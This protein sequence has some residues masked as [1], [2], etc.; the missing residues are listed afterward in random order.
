MV[1]LLTPD[2]IDRPQGSRG[3]TRSWGLSR[4]ITGPTG[5]W[6][7]LVETL[8]TPD[9]SKSVPAFKSVTDE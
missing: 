5:S 1:V 4:A 2:E 3:T 7:H 6:L 9:T 8:S